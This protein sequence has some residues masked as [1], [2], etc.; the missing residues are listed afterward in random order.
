MNKLI[1]TTIA[2]TMLAT[3]AFATPHLS[4]EC[5]GLLDVSNPETFVAALQ[6]QQDEYN[7]LIAEEVA[8]QVDTIIDEANEQIDKANAE[9]AKEAER[10]MTYIAAWEEA[11]D[12]VIELIYDIAVL[13]QKVKDANSDGAALNQELVGTVAALES[14]QR[15]LDKVKADLK[16]WQKWLSYWEPEAKRLQKR[17]RFLVD[18]IRELEKKIDWFRSGGH[19][20]PTNW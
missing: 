18:K 4:N 15:Q 9:A 20:N 2:A 3:P 14:T 11:K 5:T 17:E 6:C 1:L 12:K 19:W 10:V 7:D 13:E 8:A 16:N